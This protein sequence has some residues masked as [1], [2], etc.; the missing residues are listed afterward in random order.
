MRLRFTETTIGT[1]FMGAAITILH[2]RQ[3]K[4]FPRKTLSSF[5]A[6]EVATAFDVVSRNAFWHFADTLIPHTEVAI[7]T[8]S[9]IATFSVV[10]FDTQTDIVHAFFPIVSTIRFV[11]TLN[12]K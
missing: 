11:A 12:A 5:A 8:I 4:A 1:I 9:I 2:V 7:V 10:I 3:T 6:V